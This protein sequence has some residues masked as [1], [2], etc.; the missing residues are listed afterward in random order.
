M[1]K[2]AKWLCCS[3]TDSLRC[4]ETTDTVM[5]AYGALINL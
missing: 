4:L 3:V 2:V 5:Y 1:Q